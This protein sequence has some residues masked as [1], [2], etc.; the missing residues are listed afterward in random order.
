MSVNRG[1][2]ATDRWLCRAS[3]GKALNQ[4]AA[5]TAGA[6]GG[7]FDT[8]RWGSAAISNHLSARRWDIGVPVSKELTMLLAAVNIG[9]SV[10]TGLDAF[11]VFIPVALAFALVVLPDLRAGLFLTT[12]LA[13]NWALAAGW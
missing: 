6:P 4:A 7:P 1:Q 9:D 11:F 12:A 10:Q 2:I 13:L 8:A 5:A 3:N